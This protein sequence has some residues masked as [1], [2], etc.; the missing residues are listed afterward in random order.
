[1]SQ[2]QPKSVGGRLLLAMIR[3]G[4][5]SRQAAATELTPS[6]V[7]TLA[8]LAGL[9]EARV[10]DLAAAEGLALPVMTRLVASLDA[11]GLVT[12]APN[13]DDGRAVLLTLTEDG[14]DT[15]KQIFTARAGAVNEQIAEL[16]AKE[17]ETLEAALPVLE[18][19]ANFN[20]G[21]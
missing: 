13:P 21:K 4:R 8:T 19:L 5:L 20:L 15:I 9:T 12:K 14:Y 1:M 6:Q 17:L 2:K 3:L 18:K 16:S 7:S 10:T 11:V